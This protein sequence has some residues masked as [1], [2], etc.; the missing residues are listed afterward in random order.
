MTTKRR[1]RRRVRVR[2]GD[3]CAW[4]E[5]VDLVISV[6]GQGAARVLP[7]TDEC[8]KTLHD[9]DYRLA[10]FKFTFLARGDE[11]P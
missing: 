2:P 11:M 6:D 7:L 8:P 9:P 10:S 5:T 4:E 1:P 3:V